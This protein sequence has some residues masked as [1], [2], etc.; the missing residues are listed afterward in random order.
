MSQIMKLSKKL[1]GYILFLL[2]IIYLAYYINQNREDF[3]A[4]L[5]IAPI[6]L[7]LISVTHLISFLMNALFLKVS[8][9]P[10]QKEISLSESFFV[11][12]LTSIGN[13]FFP[14]G[15]GTGTKAVYL[16][17]KIS[18]SY[19]DFFSVL[20]ANYIIV[21]L[22]NA[23][24]GLF[25]VLFLNNKVPIFD[26]PILFVS[27]LGLFVSM[28]YLAIFGFPKFLLNKLKTMNKLDRITSLIS[29]VMFGWNLIVKNRSLTFKLL[30]ITMANTSITMTAAFF[31]AK[32][33]GFG[34][35]FVPL[36]LY[37]SLGSI[38]FILN[39]TPGSIGIKE[40]IYIY[41]SAALGLSTANIFSI[42]IVVNGTLFF[43]LIFSWVILKIPRIRKLVV[44]QA[45]EKELI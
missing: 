26:S 33:L 30:L 23:G 13:Y 43:V 16:K 32:S 24:V 17:R 12:L 29:T 34:I 5:D 3:S 39:I 6:F 4:L 11:S 14:V 7:I 20:S 19:S 25:S 45:L 21:L 1:L 44:P 22:F 28:L 2:F 18:L 8:M 10:F 41:S 27:L 9:Q 42:S 36:L 15:A 40:A 37:S 38:S 35:G 31:A